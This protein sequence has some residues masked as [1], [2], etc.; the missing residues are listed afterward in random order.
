MAMRSDLESAITETCKT[1]FNV[2]AVVKLFRPDEQ[3]GDYATNIALQLGV[4]LNRQPQEI[5]NTLAAK[6]RES[7]RDSVSEVTVAAPGFINLRLND[8]CLIQNAQ[9]RKPSVDSSGQIVVIETN[10]PN[11][12]KDIHIGHAFN[13]IIA[14]TLANLLEAG[15]AQTHRVSYHGDVGLHVGKSMWAILRYLDGDVHKLDQIAAAERPK[16]LSEKYAEGA[17]AYEQDDLAKQEIEKLTSESFSFNDPL[18]KQVYD[19]CKTWSFSYFDQVLDNLGCQNVERRYLESEADKAGREVVE[20]HL[21]DIFE[22]SDGAIIFPGEKYGVHTRVF[23]SSRNTTLYEARDLGLIQLKQRDFNP[24]ASYIVTAAEQKEY[25][26]VVLKAAELALPNL[27]GI[28]KN[29]PTGMVKLS[30][31]KMSSRQ[32]TAV[33]IGWL[34]EAVETALKARG[35]EES[36]LH[37]GLVAAIRYAFLKNGIGSDVIFDINEAI[38]L[39]GNSGIYLQYAHVRAR[40]IISKSQMQ[41]ADSF[42]NLE[43]DER[44][45]LRKITEYPDIANRAITELAPH[46]ICNYLYELAQLFNHFYEHNRVIGSEREASRLVL[47]A[48]YAQVL[49]DGLELLGIPAPQQM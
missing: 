18:F 8:Q 11:P 28:T 33:N 17:A 14:D 16:F 36:S 43:P 9:N 13:S 6:L 35:A 22:K 10:N 4:K 15:G 23:I 39:E 12:F 44:S 30:T 47:V 26:Q 24:Q 2:D 42:S 27:A 20:Q 5:A 7:L 29:I 49:K 48:D 38:S 19:I 25:F 32:G 34:L 3:F 37:P 41:P 1:L 45:L 40:S 21:G 46:H 31:G